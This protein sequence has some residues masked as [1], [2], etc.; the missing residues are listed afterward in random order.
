M[1]PHPAKQFHVGPAGYTSS[2]SCVE[3]VPALSPGLCDLPGC[4]NFLSPNV[5]ISNLQ[6]VA[7]LGPPGIVDSSS[8]SF[9]PARFNCFSHVNGSSP[10]DSQEPLSPNCSCTPSGCGSDCGSPFV[11]NPLSPQVPSASR[12]PELDRLASLEPT[13][14]LGSLDDLLSTNDSCPMCP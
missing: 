13:L 7:P 9:V 4:N 12:S 10:P 3:L 8:T 2:S 5:V 1:S 14:F 6:D 11:D